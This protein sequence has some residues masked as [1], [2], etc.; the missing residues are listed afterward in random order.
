MKTFAPGDT[1][2]YVPFADCD[3][4]LWENGIVKSLNLDDPTH[5]FVVYN[6]GG[7]WDNYENYTAESTHISCLEPNWA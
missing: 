1:V 7:N 5:V 6:C 3:S 2:R 4:S